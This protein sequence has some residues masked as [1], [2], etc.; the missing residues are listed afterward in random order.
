MAR[1]VEKHPGKDDIVPSVTVKTAKN[2]CKRPV[3]KFA[4]RL[5]ND[6]F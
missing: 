4:Q 2:S 3:V 5:P 1:F 6:I